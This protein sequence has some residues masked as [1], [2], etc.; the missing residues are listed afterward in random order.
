M[1]EEGQVRVEIFRD[2][3]EVLV[4]EPDGYTFQRNPPTYNFNAFV[5]A[6]P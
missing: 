1:T 4:F 3:S 5:A 6:S 2:E